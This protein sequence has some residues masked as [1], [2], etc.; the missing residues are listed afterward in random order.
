M[1]ERRPSKAQLERRLE[2]IRREY[3]AASARLTDVGFVCEGSLQ[4]LY[5]SCGN[6]NCRCKDPQQRHGPYW[7]ISWKEGGKTVSKLISAEDA[8][9][10]REWIANRR[11]LEAVLEDMRDLSR[12]AGEQILASTGRPFQGPQRP[13]PRRRSAS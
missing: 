1:T 13:R 10:Y 6:P 2:R 5:T 4:E 3:D 8:A 7:Q 11:R 9:L 12:Q